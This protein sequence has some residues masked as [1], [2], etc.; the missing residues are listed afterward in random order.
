M[1]AA[2]L[3][4]SHRQ[5]RR[6]G[7]RVALPRWGPGLVDRYILRQMLGWYAAVVVII[8]ALLWLEVLPR[9]ID[10]LGKVGDGVAPVMGSLLS[11][12]PEYLAVAVPIGVFLGTALTFR[13]LA[14]RGEMDALAGAG[15]SDR[16]LLR[17]PLIV[18][19]G[20]C[21]LLLGLRGYWQPA[22]ER[23]LDA[24]GRAVATGD[25]GLSFEAGRPH[26]LGPGINLY[27]AGIGPGGVLDNVF[28]QQGSISANARAARIT[29]T[30]DGQIVIL[31]SDGV[32]VTHDPARGPQ[33]SRFGG[34]RLALPIPG[35]TPAS[36]HSPRDRLDRY[37]LPSLFG[38]PPGARRAGLTPDMAL[39]AASGRAAA[40]L[41]CPL[42]PV[43][44]FGLT[45]PPK[46][47]RSGLGIGV[48]L[49]LIVLF[50]KLA[51]LI[52]DRFAAAAPFAHGTV[53]LLFAAGALWLLREQRRHGYGIMETRLARSLGYV[54]RFARART[55]MAAFHP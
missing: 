15:L 31:L 24:I 29:S 42:L 22:G 6:G 13:Q 7:V 30:R 53:L 26:R 44:A 5:A 41:F 11:L 35:H 23:R 45:I 46:R 4:A 25:Y 38:L 18:A 50:W 20:S 27:F 3:H 34:F 19:L 21:L 39:A 33:A 9:L 54:F 52:E 36:Q 40:V 48:G 43:F 16:R 1:T 14:L 47:T 8:V 51:A 12:A 28:I 32:V 2:A 10:Q 49:G 37:T 55:G 17:W